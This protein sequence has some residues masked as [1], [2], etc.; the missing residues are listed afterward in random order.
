MKKNRKIKI[1]PWIYFLLTLVLCLLQLWACSP[2]NG[3]PVR[4]D[5][6]E[7]ITQVQHLE[8][9]ITVNR[10]CDSKWTK[11]N[12]GRIIRIIKLKLTEIQLCI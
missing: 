3:S 9:K 1:P 11:N 10:R 7:V 6:P 5:L 4:L 8:S 2:Q 12:T